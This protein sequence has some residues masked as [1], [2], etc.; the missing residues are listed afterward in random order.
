MNVGQS[1]LLL[2]FHSGIPFYLFQLW[3]FMDI[4]N[5]SNDILAYVFL[6]RQ[7][8]LKRGH[9]YDEISLS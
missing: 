1:V 4:M 7:I 9:Y 6:T 3:Y 5:S 2:M 8:V